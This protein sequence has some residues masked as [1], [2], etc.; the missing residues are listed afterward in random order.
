MTTPSVPSEPTIRPVRSYPATPFA[1]GVPVRMTLPSASTISSA[2][3]NFFV[4]PYLT[5][6]RPPA[7]VATLPPIEEMRHEPGS[8]G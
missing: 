6:H 1:V 4:T 8:G 7:F 5:Q 2:R 3:T